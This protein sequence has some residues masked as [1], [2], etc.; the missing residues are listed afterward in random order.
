MTLLL[1]KHA[2]GSRV[3]LEGTLNEETE[4]ILEGDEEFEAD[5]GCDETCEE[6]ESG[7]S[8]D[9]SSYPGH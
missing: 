3:P 5:Q 4:A 9:S 1:S 2:Y 6:N 8:R 7:T